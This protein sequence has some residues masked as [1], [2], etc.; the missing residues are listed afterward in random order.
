MFNITTLPPIETDIG[1]VI[2]ATNAYSVLGIN[3]I[4]RFMHHYRGDKSIIFYFFSDLDPTDYLPDNIQFEYIHTENKIWHVGNNLRFDAVLSLEYCSSEYL[5]YFDADTNVSKEFTEEW[6]LGDLVGGQHFLDQRSM[7]DIKGY[8]RNKKSCVY[9]PHDTIHPQMYYYGAFWG[10]KKENVVEF[11]RTIQTHRQLD[12]ENGYNPPYNEKY[13]NHYFHYNPP[14]KSVLNK[15]F[16]FNI[17]TKG[18]L[19]NTR[20]IDL[21]IEQIKKDLLLNKDKNTNIVNGNVI[22]QNN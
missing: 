7:K 3:F 2:T 10:G 6:F 20:V 1:I 14:T 19:G 11:C 8:E 4:K 21:D 17:S 18:G 9:I 22:V 16:A 12:I 13:I 15:D 5:Y